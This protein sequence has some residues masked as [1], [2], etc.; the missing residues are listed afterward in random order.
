MPIPDPAA[1]VVALRDGGS[2][3]EVLVVKRNPRGFFG[4]LVVFPGGRVDEVDSAISGESVMSEA[5]H[6]HAAVREL[7]EEAGM[8][9]TDRGIEP[10]PG[11]K[12]DEFYDW[13]SKHDKS[14][15]PERLVLISR[16]VTPEAAPR[17]FD[18]RFYLLACDETPDVAIDTDE[19]VDHRWVSPMTALEKH[20][21]GDWPMWLP[22][23]AHLRWLTKRSSLA[24]A[25]SSAE[26]ADG[27]TLIEPRKVED[28]SIV[29]IHLPAE[30]S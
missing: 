23:I 25:I 26:G 8:L 21:A 17:R 10:A 18:T 19:L 29:P 14:L 13:V 24:D 16:W 20:Q 5:S 30:V 4:S 12:G 2:G 28:G 11:V 27:R 15:A 7:S 3:L 9:L 1:T 6:R 22:T